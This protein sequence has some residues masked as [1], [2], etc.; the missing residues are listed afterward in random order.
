MAIDTNTVQTY[1]APNQN[2]EDLAKQIYNVD[3]FKTPVLNM[4]KK[5][6]ATNIKHEWTVDVL[7]AQNTGNAQIE[8][9]VAAADQIYAAGRLGNYCQIS[10]KVVEISR[11]EQRANSVGRFG[12]M[13]YQLLKAS[14]ALKRDMEGI[15]T[16]NNAQVAG[17][18]STARV[19][20]GIESYLTANTVSLGTGAAVPTGV[21]A[22]GNGVNFGNGTTARTAGTAP[23]AFSEAAV[24]TVVLD[25][26]NASGENIEYMVM[27]GKNK[28]IA[29][30]FTGVTGT[31]FNQVKDN[32]FNT[33]ID[34]YET[35]FGPTKFVPDIWLARSGDVFGINP[36]Y[37]GVAFF[38]PFQ[39]VP[40][41]KT[42]DSDKKMLIV[43]YALEV[44]NERALGA[45]YDTTG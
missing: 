20:G 36:E 21:T 4:A 45:V 25:V 34:V 43:E 28:Q 40:L 18:T 13:A 10:R 12:S 17:N 1:T 2:R 9:D 24:R 23:T 39:T 7:P 44:R 38:D 3:P 19:T 22:A 15:L 8:G 16:S 35:D 31:R 30:T 27:S 5:A 11:T 33:A 41:A 32:R 26:F 14:K 42:G 29:S 37:I 6:K